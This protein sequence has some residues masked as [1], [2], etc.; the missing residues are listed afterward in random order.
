MIATGTDDDKRKIIMAKTPLQTVADARETL[1]DDV[2][3]RLQELRDEITALTQQLRD[4]GLKGAHEAKAKAKDIAD[5]ATDEALAAIKELR[6][7]FGS[8]QAEVEGKVQTHPFAWL[9]GAVGLGVIL[10][11]FLTH[12]D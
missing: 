10:G 11:L 3:S 8:M 7:Q 12:R 5:D 9:L 2:E 4:L 1:H 6:K